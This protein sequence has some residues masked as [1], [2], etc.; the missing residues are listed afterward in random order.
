MP[1]EL[2]PPDD[3]L[4]TTIDGALAKAFMGDLPAAMST[5]G[6]WLVG[7]AVMTDTPVSELNGLLDAA[8]KRSRETRAE[9]AKVLGSDATPPLENWPIDGAAVPVKPR[10]QSV[11]APAAPAPV[12]TPAPTPAARAAEALAAASTNNDAP[13]RAPQVEILPPAYGDEALAEIERM[14]KVAS[15]STKPEQGDPPEALTEPDLE[16]EQ[17]D[18]PDVAPTDFGDEPDLEPGPPTAEAEQRDPEAATPSIS[19]KP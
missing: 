9:V 1:L 16:P 10:L 2:T 8:F 19:E 12:P 13:A 14:K 6:T 11:P 3:A 17:G 4:I 18:P 15:E 5:V 7:M